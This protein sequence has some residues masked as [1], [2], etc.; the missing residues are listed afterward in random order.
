MTEC[1]RL[2]S[3]IQKKR[4]ARGW[5]VEGQDEQSFDKYKDRTGTQCH[6]EKHDVVPNRKIPIPSTRILLR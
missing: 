1:L 6:L 5:W 4:G 2:N 3:P